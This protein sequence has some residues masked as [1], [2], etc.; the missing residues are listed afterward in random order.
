M[1]AGHRFGFEPVAVVGA[2]ILV[3][4][5]LYQRLVNKRTWHSILWGVYAS[6][7]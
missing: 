3:G 1:L 4:A 5:L 7:E 6:K 2:V